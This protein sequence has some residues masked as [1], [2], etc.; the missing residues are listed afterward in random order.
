[1]TGSWPKSLVAR[2]NHPLTRKI[3][4]RSPAILGRLSSGKWQKGGRQ[5]CLCP[6][7]LGLGLGGDAGRVVEG[8][9]GPPIHADEPGRLFPPPQPGA[10]RRE[11]RQVE[12]AA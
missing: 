1:M 7:F 9:V 8:G 10:D 12:I 5:K 3:S 11:S 2:A 4:Q 6:L